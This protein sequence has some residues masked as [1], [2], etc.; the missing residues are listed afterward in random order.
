MSRSK[1]S[2]SRGN[3]V[4]PHEVMKTYG[5]DAVRYYLMRIGGVANDAG[6]VLFH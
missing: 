5:I 4:D 6:E 3:V 1:M 2:K